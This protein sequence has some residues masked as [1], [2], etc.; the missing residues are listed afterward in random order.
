MTCAISGTLVFR[1][2]PAGLAQQVNVSVRGIMT[3]LC[4]WLI[5]TIL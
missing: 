4:T 2:T 5:G 1:S 3:N